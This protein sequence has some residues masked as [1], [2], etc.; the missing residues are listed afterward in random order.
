MQL[1]INDSQ[2]NVILNLV[3]KTV[4]IELAIIPRSEPAGDVLG[5]RNKTRLLDLGLILVAQD[6]SEIMYQIDQRNSIYTFEAPPGVQR[7]IVVPTTGPARDVW[8]QEFTIDVQQ[9]YRCTSQFVEIDYSTI[10]R[11]SPLPEDAS[12]LV[13]KIG[14]AAPEVKDN[15]KAIKGIGPKLEGQLNE[16]G[17]YTYRQLSKM[18]DPEYELLDNLLTSFKGRAKKDDWAGQARKLMKK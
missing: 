11:S 18:T 8:K 12:T 10:D 13:G 17:I 6:G 16:L 15:L 5:N 14:A 2:Y 7:I 3:P 9:K 4:K 1:D